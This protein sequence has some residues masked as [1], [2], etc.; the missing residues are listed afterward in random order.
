MDYGPPPTAE[1]ANALMVEHFNDVLKD[2]ESARYRWGSDPIR[3]W[4]RETGA[5]TK[6]RTFAGWLVT[7]DVNAKNSYGGY[8]G[9]ATYRFLIRNDSIVA[10][11]SGAGRFSSLDFTHP[12]PR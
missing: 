1:R 10:V 2:S 11:D 12:D 5:A 3:Y 7:A 9:F 6:K 4:F 8:A